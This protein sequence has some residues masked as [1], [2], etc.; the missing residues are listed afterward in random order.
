MPLERVGRESSSLVFDVEEEDPRGPFLATEVDRD[1]KFHENS[2]HRGAPRGYS[3]QYRV[4]ACARDSTHNETGERLRMYDERTNAHHHNF[5]TISDARANVALS[6]HALRRR[7]RSA[8][9]ESAT[10]AR[11]SDMVIKLWW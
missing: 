7:R 10:L 6:W 1:L 3:S 11:A 9:Q 2:T 5:I 4:R 8:C